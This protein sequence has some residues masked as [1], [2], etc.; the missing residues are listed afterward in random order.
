LLWERRNVLK[1]LTML[2]IFAA[3]ALCA[4][5]SPLIVGA[6]PQEPGIQWLTSL[7]EA[8]VQAQTS[9]K[10]VLLDFFNPN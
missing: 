6:G 3:L 5:T 9:N 1:I 4:T 10:P 8:L 7:D 2:T